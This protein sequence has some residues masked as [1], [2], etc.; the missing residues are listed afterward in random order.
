MLSLSVQARFQPLKKNRIVSLDMQEPL[1]RSHG[2]WHSFV[3]PVHRQLLQPQ[4]FPLAGAEQ[5]HGTAILLMCPM[6]GPMPLET[7]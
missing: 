1:E 3:P 2:R 5:L 4:I 7:P 6:G